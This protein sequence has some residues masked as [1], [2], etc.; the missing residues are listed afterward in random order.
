MQELQI[1]LQHNFS[2]SDLLTQALTHKSFRN[3]N[4]ETQSDNEKL[5]FLGDAVLDL[6]LSQYLMV[7]FPMDDEGA[8]SKK[9]ASLV[10]EDSL[11]QIAREIALDRLLRL[12][13]GELRTGGLAKPRLL[14]SSFE[15]MIGAL[16]VDGGY[17]VAAAVI[18]RL[19]QNKILQI[20]LTPDFAADFK[21]RL[22]ERAQ[23]LFKVTPKYNV[24][25]EVGPDHDKKFEVSVWI[26][27]SKFAS[28]E[29]RSKKAAEQEAARVALQKIESDHAA[30]NAAKESVN[31][32]I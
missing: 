22:Q 14:A 12:G 1:L 19:F 8:L 16:F 2:N 24:D 27:D 23:E 13:K 21:T 18:K 25:G 9:R 11:S 4:L 5:E 31:E 7:Q 17:E 6:A 29:G 15:A 3:E 10:N 30:A 32:K 28:G 26:Q 20:A